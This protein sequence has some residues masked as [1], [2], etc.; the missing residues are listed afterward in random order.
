MSDTALDLIQGSLRLLGVLASGEAASA[1][2]ATD[3]LSAL[4]DMLDSWSNQNLLIPNKVREVFAITTSKQTYTMGTGGDFN[5]TRPIAIENILIQLSGSSPA[6]EIPLQIITK[7]EYA[8]ITVKGL[9]STYPVAAY[10]EGTYPLE[11]INLWPSPNSGNNLVIYSAKPLANL[12]A[13]STA[14]SLPPGYQRAL[15]YNLAAELAPEYGKQLPEAVELGAVNSKAEIKRKNSRPKY[16]L[17]DDSI[18]ARP[19]GW[20]WRTGEPR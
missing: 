19:V 1:A 11:T 4:N 20:D 12:S 18:S 5:T 13:L 8:D 15:R 6:V 3:G 10:A 9:T 7:D 16:L 14:I 17:V 2:E